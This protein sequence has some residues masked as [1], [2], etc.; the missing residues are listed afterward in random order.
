MKQRSNI[1][2]RRGVTTIEFAL[3]IPF[4]FVLVL[5]MVEF[6]SIFYSWL[7]IQKAAQVGARF[8]ATGVGDEE[9]NR[10]SQIVAETEK[11]LTALDNGAKEITVSSWPTASATGDGVEND[12]GGPCELVQ[13]SVIYHYHPFTPLVG[14]VFPE[15]INLEG[16]ERKLNEPWKPCGE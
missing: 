14:D 12:P 3:I 9:G 8:A 6:G 11:W 16:H 1:A 10:L 4:I 7:S 13:V 15:V 5:G 2:R